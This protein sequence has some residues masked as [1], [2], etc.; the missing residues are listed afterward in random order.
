MNDRIRSLLNQMTA[1][2]D[3]M[4]TVLH[5]QETKMFFEIKGKRIEFEKAIKHA[6][7]ILERQNDMLDLLIL[8]IARITRSGWRNTGSHWGN[9]YE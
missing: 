6:R 3:E 5:S 2:E 8:A 7:K 1:L 4:R 9:R